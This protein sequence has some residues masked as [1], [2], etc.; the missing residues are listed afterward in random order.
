MKA[1]WARV[2]IVA[3]IVLLLCSQLLSGLL[4]ACLVVHFLIKDEF[5]GFAFVYYSAPLAILAVLALGLGW[6]WWLSQRMQFARL[7]F[8]FATLAFLAW[9]Y[10]S[11]S[12]NSKKATPEN[13]KIFFWNA[14]GNN[15]TN[16]IAGYVHGFDADV[17]GMVESGMRSRNVSAWQK[18]FPEYHVEKL[19]GNMALLTKGTLLSKATGSLGGR[20][21]FNLLEVG[22]KGK[23]LHVLLVDFDSDPFRSR[24]PAFEPLLQLIRAY[25][26]TNL[27]V[28][29]DFNTPLE[30]VFFEPFHAY[31]DHAFER[32]GNGFAESWPLPLPV[33]TID[34]IWVSKKI[35]VIN[36]NLNWSQ[37][38]DHRPVLANVAL[39]HD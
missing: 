4:L 27:I 5:A 1:M 22:L 2:T 11:F 37:Y 26:Q 28:M 14:A 16:E 23:E 18:K 9:S 35:N 24:A 15:S 20:G 17:I 32:G 39:P 34:H 7:C 6:L 8:L 3:R 33:L 36:C 29:G 10:K 30:S 21:R 12:F 38:S 25:A 13:V 31:L 19:G